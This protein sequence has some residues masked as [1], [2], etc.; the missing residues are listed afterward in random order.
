MMPFD[1][2][3]AL[4]KVKANAYDDSDH[5]RLLGALPFG[6]ILETLGLEA[7]ALILAAGKQHWSLK[8]QLEMQWRDWQRQHLPDTPAAESSGPP[9]PTLSLPEQAQKLLEH[10]QHEGNSGLV[11]SELERFARLLD[12][13]AEIS[14]PQPVP[15]V[16]PPAPTMPQAKRVQWE[17]DLRAQHEYRQV[18]AE[19]AWR[20]LTEVLRLRGA[21]AQGLEEWK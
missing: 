14:A 21:W 17:E 16:M 5:H 3:E 12:P 15:L 2:P 7:E 18:E 8:S 6:L 1:L 13:A 11:Q 4:G 20:S 10:I 19:A 9:E